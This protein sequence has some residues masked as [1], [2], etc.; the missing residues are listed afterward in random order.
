[1]KFILVL[2]AI[3][4][5]LACGCTAQ[6][7]APASV[8]QTRVQDLPITNEVP[9]QVPT[10]S[11][12]P[13]PKYVIGDVIAKT[14]PYYIQGF[15]IAGYNETTGKYQRVELNRWNYGNG[16]YGPW[17]KAGG[18]DWEDLDAT[19]MEASYQKYLGHVNP[20]EIPGVTDGRTFERL[21][22]AANEA[23]ETLQCMQGVG[24]LDYCL[25]IADKYGIARDSM[26]QSYCSTDP[27]C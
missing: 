11:Q 13:P 26:K 21:D 27:F 9:H 1:M 18:N 8:Q 3:G 19:I 10:A 25:K 2:L 17:K 20:D 23:R 6:Q 14:G 24:G 22:V 16:N 15:L 4:F 12:F 7:A 5:I